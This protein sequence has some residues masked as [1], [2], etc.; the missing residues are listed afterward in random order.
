M[1]KLNQANKEIINNIKLDN[2]WNNSVG[3]G[4]AETISV[5][6]QT[7]R[8]R[9][10]ANRE[11]LKTEQINPWQIRKRDLFARS[12]RNNNNVTQHQ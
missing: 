6:F 3:F 8:K 4:I 1:S 10:I 5:L 2:N 9:K 7:A 12:K 11:P